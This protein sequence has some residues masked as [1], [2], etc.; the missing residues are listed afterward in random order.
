M[1]ISGNFSPSSVNYTCTFNQGLTSTGIGNCF[2]VPSY[3]QAILLDRVPTSE[4]SRVSLKN[5]HLINSEKF[6]GFGIIR[7]LLPVNRPPPRFE[8][9]YIHQ[10]R[11]GNNNNYGSFALASHNNNRG[12]RILLRNNN[13]E[14]M[15]SY[16]AKQMGRTHSYNH[17]RKPSSNSTTDNMEDGHI[18][19]RWNLPLF[20]NSSNNNIPDGEERVV[21]RR[22]NTIS[23]GIDISP[24]AR[25][26]HPGVNDRAPLINQSDHHGY[27]GFI[28]IFEK[29]ILRIGIKQKPI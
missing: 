17:F 24:P 4:S 3:S 21:P 1:S 2:M 20:M 8:S 23:E 19:S 18:G 7:N 6:K 10:P 15:Q 14:S 9:E 22:S 16:Q 25:F 11:Y 12:S 28:L 27:S 26:S 29:Q 13:N 5:S